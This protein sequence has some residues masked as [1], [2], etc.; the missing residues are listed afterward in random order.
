MFEARDGAAERRLIQ[1]AVST[2]SWRTRAWVSCLD[3]AGT[4]YLRLRSAATRS[5]PHAPAATASPRAHDFSVVIV[6][7]AAS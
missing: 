1:S 5:R 3:P 2:P 7:V 6:D 4:H